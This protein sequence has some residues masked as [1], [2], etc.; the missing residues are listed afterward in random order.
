MMMDMFWRGCSKVRRIDASMST[1]VKPDDDEKEQ[2]RT[3][4]VVQFAK[5]MH[6]TPKK[7][8]E[9]EDLQTI[10]APC[11]NENSFQAHYSPILPTLYIYLKVLL[12]HRSTLWF[13]VC[14]YILLLPNTE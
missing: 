1:N 9:R 10:V 6:D 12:N 2:K 7:N 4:Y 5:S 14:A 8:D 3:A 11:W 13:A